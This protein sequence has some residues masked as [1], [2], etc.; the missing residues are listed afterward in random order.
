MLKKLIVK[1][2]SIKKEGSIVQG[3]G[4]KHCAQ[5]LVTYVMGVERIVIVFPFGMR[6]KVR[7]KY[8]R[9]NVS[10]RFAI[11]MVYEILRFSF[12]SFVF[13]E[14][15]FSTDKVV[16][17]MRMTL[18]LD[19]KSD[20]A[21]VMLV[22]DQEGLHLQRASIWYITDQVII[23]IWCTLRVSC[24]LNDFSSTSSRTYIFTDY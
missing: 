23:S 12:E 19:V 14:L 1:S 20:R 13:Q 21:H 17:F 5:Y 11:A 7:S 10:C 18:A 8:W 24:A 3:S 22:Y 9:A 6:Y 16:L 4:L 2:K 15:Y